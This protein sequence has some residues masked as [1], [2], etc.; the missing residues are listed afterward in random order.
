MKLI[1][2][3]FFNYSSS[4]CYRK[5]LKQFLN[6]AGGSPLQPPNHFH[7]VNIPD[8][9][10]EQLALQALLICDP[11]CDDYDSNETDFI[12]FLALAAY[13]LTKS[14]ALDKS[15]KISKIERLKIFLGYSRAVLGE[16]YARKDNQTNP[17]PLA[18]NDIFKVDLDPSLEAL[19]QN[20]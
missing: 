15:I 12:T 3:S 5:N 13:S 9:I 17:E 19:L 10:L 2:Y 14:M 11:E 1:P 16:Y 7:P 8:A 18:L 20:S 4:E 6:W